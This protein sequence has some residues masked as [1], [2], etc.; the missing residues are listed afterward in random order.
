M[1]GTLKIHN[2]VIFVNCCSI[3][4]Q[5][6]GPSESLQFSEK[7]RRVLWCIREMHCAEE[8]IARLRVSVVLL[9]YCYGLL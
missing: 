7:D 9:C 6:E 5:V 4:Q 2:T 8:S 1:K 3:S